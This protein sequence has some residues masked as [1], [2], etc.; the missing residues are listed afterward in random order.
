MNGVHDYIIHE[1][2]SRQEKVNN[3]YR[4]NQQFAILQN[5]RQIPPIQSAVLDANRTEIGG[6]QTAPNLP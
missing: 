2:R 5:D 4:Y 6:L 1:A 3:N